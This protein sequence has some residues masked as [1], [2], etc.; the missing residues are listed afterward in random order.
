MWFNYYFNYYSKISL[1]RSLTPDLS[2]EKKRERESES[3]LSVSFLSPST[4][5]GSLEGWRGGEGLTSNRPWSSV[6]YAYALRVCRASYFICTRICT[7]IHARVSSDMY[8]PVHHLRM[9]VN[10]RCT[11][12]SPDSV[13]ALTHTRTH[14][15]IR[16][17]RT[18]RAQCRGRSYT[19]I[20]ARNVR[21]VALVKWPENK[22]TT[23][24]AALIENAPSGLSLWSASLPFK[25]HLRKLTV[26]MIV[27]AAR[28]ASMRNARFVFVYV[29]LLPSCLVYCDI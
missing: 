18:R 10:V 11:F 17:R 2:S 27:K 29:S 19:A 22:R 13:R 14:T 7:H 6:L 16:T 1:V 20:P 28:V 21:H 26:P 8:A 4:S 24:L 5:E 23:S 25:S 9:H 12:A 3:S 15:H